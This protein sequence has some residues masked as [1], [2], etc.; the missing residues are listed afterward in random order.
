HESDPHGKKGTSQLIDGKPVVPPK[1]GKTSPP[2]T[3]VKPQTAR[4]PTSA[5]GGPP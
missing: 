5:T 4:E 2:Q 1:P 3:N